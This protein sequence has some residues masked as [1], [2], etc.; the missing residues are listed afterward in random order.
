MGT[1]S[2]ENKPYLKRIGIEMNNF[3]YAVLVLF[4]LNFV[5]LYECVNVKQLS[6]NIEGKNANSFNKNLGQLSKISKIH[7]INQQQL[8]QQ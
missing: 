5:N 7:W 4:L 3:F 6:Q 1:Y 8:Q 2:S